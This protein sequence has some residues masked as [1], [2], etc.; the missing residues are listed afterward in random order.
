MIFDSGL[1]DLNHYIY[2]A[3]V[4][5]FPF[6]L[7][8][9]RQKANGKC[10]L[11]KGVIHLREACV[12]HL[13]SHSYIPW[14]FSSMF[15]FAFTKLRHYNRKRLPLIGEEKFFS[16]NPICPGHKNQAFLFLWIVETDYFGHGFA[17]SAFLTFQNFLRFLIVGILIGFGFKVY[18]F[19]LRFGV[20]SF[21]QHSTLLYFVL[22]LLLNNCS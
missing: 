7:V 6:R 3:P 22:D 21:L 9:L 5:A 16:Y 15:V 20:R 8:Y 17:A 12:R 4:D 1:D 2:L 18:N 14:S 11:F 13:P 10:E 19:F